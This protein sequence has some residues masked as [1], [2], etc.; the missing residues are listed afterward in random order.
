MWRIL[1]AVV[2]EESKLMSYRRI[3]LALAVLCAA[4]GAAA[5]QWTG[6][7]EV[8]T[9]QGK[10]AVTPDWRA[11]N[12]QKLGSRG[13][14]VRADKREGQEAYLKRLMCE[15]GATPTYR[16]L[17]MSWTGPYTT[18]V[19]GYEVKCPDDFAIVFM[20]MY[21]PGYVERRPVPDFQ[22]RSAR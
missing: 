16:R 5:Q 11:I 18:P 1:A 15:G 6:P 19:D 22:I 21:H 3:A 13:N 2:V 9:R 14:P 17:P 8:E 20:D 12:A 4:G 7:I 10:K